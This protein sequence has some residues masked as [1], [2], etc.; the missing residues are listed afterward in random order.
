MFP[1][2]DLAKG[3][4]EYIQGV[5][6]NSGFGEEYDYVHGPVLVRVTGNLSPSKA[7]DYEVAFG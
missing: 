4:A 1:D 7:R 3:R 6:K 2:A 5:L